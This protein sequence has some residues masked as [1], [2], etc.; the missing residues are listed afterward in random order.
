[1]ENRRE[2]AKK[3]AGIDKHPVNRV[4]LDPNDIGSDHGRMF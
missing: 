2:L 1:M 3:S 4:N